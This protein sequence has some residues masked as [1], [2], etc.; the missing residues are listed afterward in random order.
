MSNEEPAASDLSSAECSPSL[1]INLNPFNKNRMIFDAPAWIHQ[2]WTWISI[3]KSISPTK[4]CCIKLI[5]I[6][7]KSFSKSSAWCLLNSIFCYSVPRELV[8]EVS[9]NQCSCF[10]SMSCI[11]KCT[12]FA[13][14][15]CVVPPGVLLT[16]LSLFSNITRLALLDHHDSLFPDYNSR[17]SPSTEILCAEWNSRLRK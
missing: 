16:L 15:V 7:D 17:T 11:M 8:A 2:Q 1:W 5:R 10:L 12:R 14:T 3:S 13:W 6:A 4:Y 9:A